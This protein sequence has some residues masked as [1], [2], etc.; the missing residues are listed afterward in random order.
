[1]N[2]E[3][4]KEIKEINPKIIE[5]NKSIKDLNTMKLDGK[6]KYLIKPT[7]FIELKKILIVI[8][9]YNIKYHIIGN[10]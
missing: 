2:N 6:V 9:K 1:M 3:L 5:I 10:G 4:I 8:K 7:S